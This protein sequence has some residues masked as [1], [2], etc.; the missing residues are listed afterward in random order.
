MQDEHRWAIDAGEQLCG[1]RSIPIGPSNAVL[2]FIRVIPIDEFRGIS[3][4][5][6]LLASLCEHNS[7][8][9]DAKR[10]RIARS[11]EFLWDRAA[12]AEPHLSGSGGQ[13][14]GIRI[15]LPLQRVQAFAIDQ[16]MQVWIF[17]ERCAAAA[18]SPVKQSLPDR[19]YHWAGR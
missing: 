12:R 4:D 13:A 14:K 17:G 18:S 19:I 5:C 11:P 10:A 3:V 8:Q 6:A 15:T 1:Y 2:W 16:Q 7:P 9:R